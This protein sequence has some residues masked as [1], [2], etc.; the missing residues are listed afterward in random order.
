METGVIWACQILLERYKLLQDKL[1]PRRFP[2]RQEKTDSWQTEK[3]ASEDTG[4][5]PILM[6]TDCLHL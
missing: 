6:Q 1:N 4:E 2:W 5:F 3:S